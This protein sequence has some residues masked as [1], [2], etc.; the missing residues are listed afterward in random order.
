MRHEQRMV[1]GNKADKTDA[2][3]K[4]EKDISMSNFQIKIAG[5][6]IGINSKYEYVSRL[7]EEYKVSGD[8][9]TGKV[10]FSVSATEQEIL[11]EQAGSTETS[12]PYCESLCLYRAICLRLVPYDAFLMHSAALALDGEAYV[13]AAKSG[14]GKTTHM[15]L[16]MDEFGE[17]TQ[18]INGDKPIYRF[19]D[20]V[21][22]ACGTPW[23]GKERL[24]SNI[25]VPVKAIYF[26]EQS[27]EN[28]IRPLGEGEVI[29]RIFHQL[30]MPR[31]E[32]E[33]DRFVDLIERMI[34][35]V[36]CYLLSCNMER[37]AALLAYKRR[38]GVK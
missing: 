19:M 34:T 12:L 1:S 4:L 25:M 13:F 17:R 35:S 30:L 28:R 31:E 14:V 22:H 15:K 36:D 24:G 23:Q 5:L 21:L 20:G 11:E 9:S 7:C 32:E 10:D 16:W 26:L 29:G 33:L 2:M 3:P 8:F 38:G 6:V 18:V 37:E 27:A